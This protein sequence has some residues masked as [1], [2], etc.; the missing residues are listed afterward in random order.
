MAERQKSTP[1]KSQRTQIPAQTNSILVSLL[2]DLGALLMVTRSALCRF[3][4]PT[5]KR[6]AAG[7][8]SP[9]TS[10]R[11]GSKFVLQSSLVES[12]T[13]IELHELHV[14]C[15]CCCCVRIFA[16]MVAGISRWTEQT[17]AVQLAPFSV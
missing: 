5:L 12:S 10:G 1:Q 17:L 11:V 9:L 6:T 3:E 7:L 4:Q 14:S 8:L 15:C 16:A 2:N 13:E